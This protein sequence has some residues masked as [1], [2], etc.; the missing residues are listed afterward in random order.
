MEQAVP[1]WF[2]HDVDVYPLCCQ[3]SHVKQA[4]AEPTLERDNDVKIDRHTYID[5]TC[6]TN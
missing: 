6:L 4:V 5:I 3:G 2:L 1:G